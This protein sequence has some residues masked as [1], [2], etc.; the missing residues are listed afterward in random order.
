MLLA[1]LSGTAA[2]LPLPPGSDP[3]LS[4]DEVERAAGP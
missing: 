3:A 2:W 4:F 1:W